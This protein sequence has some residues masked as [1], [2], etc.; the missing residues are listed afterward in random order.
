MDRLIFPFDGILRIETV[1]VAE[2]EL[3]D[4]LDRDI[5]E[6]DSKHKAKVLE[7]P[8]HITRLLKN[9]FAIELHTMML[10]LLDEIHNLTTLAC[11]TH[12]G[13]V[14]VGLKVLRAIELWSC[15]EHLL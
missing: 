12:C 15:S 10:V 9:L 13:V 8:E 2:P 5:I 3:S 4:I 7:I 14:E 1:L 6:L 11:E